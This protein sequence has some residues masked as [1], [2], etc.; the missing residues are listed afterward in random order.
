MRE[1]SVA[2]PQLDLDTEEKQGG[3]GNG[4]TGMGKEE[5]PKT[6]EKIKENYRKTGT[7]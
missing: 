7:K 6:G 3:T 1:H 4:E 5:M 2:K